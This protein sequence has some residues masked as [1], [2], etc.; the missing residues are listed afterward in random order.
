MSAVRVK[1]IR[2]RGQG[3]RTVYTRP[4]ISIGRGL[5]A[6]KPLP[7]S[8]SK[9]SSPEMRCDSIVHWPA[10]ER[11]PKNRFTQ[12]GAH[13]LP[14]PA[15]RRRRGRPPINNRAVF[16]IL[17]VLKEAARSQA[18]PKESG[19]S[20]TPLAPARTMGI[21]RR[22]AEGLAGALRTGRATTLGLGAVFRRREFRSRQKG[23]SVPA[24][25]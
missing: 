18:L 12:L 2:G 13:L 6:A 9:H 1:K 21:T 4:G 15:Q 24:K 25:P 5:S 3:T 10:P 11:E 17:G 22:V 16:M 7:R 23:A 20:L 14:Q 8:R 19:V